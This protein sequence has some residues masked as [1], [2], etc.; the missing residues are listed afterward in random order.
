[1]T[2]WRSV[3]DRVAI[4]VD[5]SVQMLAGLLGILKAGAAYVPLDPYF[6]RDRLTYMLESSAPAAILTQQALQ[7]FLPTGSVPV[8]LLDPELAAREGFLA[9]PGTP[10]LCHL[11]LRFH[12]VAEGRADQ[13]S[14]LEQLPPRHEP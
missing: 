11:H 2:G 4:C 7:S 5:R 1:M 8:L 3:S 9:A 14:G 12:R 10:G 13:P 6:P